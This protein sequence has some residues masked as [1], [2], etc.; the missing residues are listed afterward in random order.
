MT[1]NVKAGDSPKFYAMIRDIYGDPLSVSAA[2]LDEFSY[3][4]YKV[5]GGR[6]FPVEGFVDVPIDSSCYHVE[7][8]DVPTGLVGDSFEEYNVEIFPYRAVEVDG[9]SEWVSPFSEVNANYDLAVKMR[10]A[11]GDPALDGTAFINKEFAIRI[12][13]S[14]A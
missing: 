14:E 13:V 1:V 10:Y 5:A 3:T 12:N 8:L 2:E 6:R 7:P 11:M 9:V 4:V